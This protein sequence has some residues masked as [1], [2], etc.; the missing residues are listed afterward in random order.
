[1]V[2]KTNSN[3]RNRLYL[4]AQILL[5]TTILAVCLTL[6]KYKTVSESEVTTIVAL[7]EFSTTINDINLDKLGPNTA[8][9]N[10]RFKIQ[11]FDP[12]N[13]SKISEINLNY[14]IQIK[15]GN[16]LP[17]KF[18]LHPII[19]GTVVQ[20]EN[21]FSN[22]TGNITDSIIFNAGVATINE[23][24]LVI[25]WD[26]EEKDYKYSDEIDFVQILVNCSQTKNS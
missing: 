10:Y 12:E 14:T 9:S 8:S 11:N 19:D 20:E 26:S 23:Y 22:N 15:S 5:I 6:S 16:Y 3:K 2:K 1:M 17:L 4:F 18:E 24:M 13:N 7:N 21:L 25:K